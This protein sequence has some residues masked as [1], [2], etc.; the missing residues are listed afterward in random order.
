METDVALYLLNSPIISDF[1]HWSYRGPLTVTEAREIVAEGFVSAIG[2]FSTANLLTRILGRQVLVNRIPV[3]FEPG[4]RA[5]VFQLEQRLSEGRI[6]GEAEL[7]RTGF[8]LG[9]LERLP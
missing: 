2:H 8:R 6:L 4:D 7:L 3:V 5:L 9:L 1:G